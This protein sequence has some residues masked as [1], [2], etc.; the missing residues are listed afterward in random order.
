MYTVDHF[1]ECRDSYYVHAELAFDET[2]RYL[3]FTPLSHARFLL[4][5]PTFFAGGTLY[6]LHAPDLAAHPD[7]W[8][9]PH[10]P[11]NGRA[12]DQGVWPDLHPEVRR[13]GDAH[14]RVGTH[15]A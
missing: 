10:R 13:D 6:T 2:T 7:L 4:F 3:A 12:A 15:E 9:S 1:L 8:R 14:G 11:D 5:L